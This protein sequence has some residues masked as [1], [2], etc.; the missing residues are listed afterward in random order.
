MSLMRHI[1]S[2]QRQVVARLQN[3]KH[4]CIYIYDISNLLNDVIA[5]KG[6][7]LTKYSKCKMLK[8]NTHRQAHAGSWDISGF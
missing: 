3:A 6:T 2:D 7:N 1:R 4:L 5:K 8:C